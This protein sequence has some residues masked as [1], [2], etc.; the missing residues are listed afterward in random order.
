MIEKKSI[1][2]VWREHQARVISM[3]GFFNYEPF[4]L[5]GFTNKKSLKIFEY[6]K[7]MLCTL[8]IFIRKNPSVIWIQLPPTPLL[9]CAFFYKLIKRRNLV[10]IADCHNAMLRK[11]WVTTPFARKLLSRCDII[12]V[13]NDD[14]KK[15]LQKINVQQQNSLVLE[16]NSDFTFEIENQQSVYGDEKKNIVVF[17]ASFNSDEPIMELLKVAQNLPDINLYITGDYKKAPKKFLEKV[18]S[19]V[20]LTGYINKQDYYGIIY[21]A[22]VVLGL[23]LLNDIQLS[24]ANEGVAFTKAMVLSNTETLKSIF[25]KGAIFVSSDAL[26]ITNGIITALKNKKD[27]ESEASELKK[28]RI[29][30]WRQQAG[31]IAKIIEKGSVING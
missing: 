5:K 30:K 17:P 16:D 11:P 21:N 31:K 27:L 3:Q 20:C 25:Y 26:S 4:F 23:T 15:S 7:Q 14:V 19:N 13:H 18:P 2:I 1:Y 24:V 8:F 10:L 9:Y 12:L 29:V 28:E 6:L 22:D